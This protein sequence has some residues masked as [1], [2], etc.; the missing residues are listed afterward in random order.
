M[1]LD[2]VEIKKFEIIGIIE[3]NNK[4]LSKI[5]LFVLNEIMPARDPFCMIIYQIKKKL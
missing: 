5:V 1:L 4:T 3:L 2:Q